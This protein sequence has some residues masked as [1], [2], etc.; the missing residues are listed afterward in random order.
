MDPEEF[1]VLHSLSEFTSTEKLE[2][3]WEV[4]SFTEVLLRIE[5]ERSSTSSMSVKEGGYADYYS[6]YLNYVKL[7]FKSN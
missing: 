6:Y 2:I 3:A 5:A 1:A 7:K 4:S